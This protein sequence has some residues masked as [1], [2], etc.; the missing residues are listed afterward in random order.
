MRARF[1][2]IIRTYLEPHV[3]SVMAAP[4]QSIHWGIGLRE[5]IP[6]I[7][8]LLFHSSCFLFFIFTFS[9]KYK[10]AQFFSIRNWWFLSSQGLELESGECFLCNVTGQK[11]WEELPPS[12]EWVLPLFP[13]RVVGFWHV[14]KVL[15]LPQSWEVLLLWVLTSQF[16]CVSLW[17]LGPQSSFHHPHFGAVFGVIL[18]QGGALALHGG[19][20]QLRAAFQNLSDQSA[21]GEGRDTVWLQ[22]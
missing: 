15:V 22:L 9:V 13:Q 6:T 2:A 7:N 12:S 5:S 11:D 14:G 17:S 21:Q 16:N 19:E 4:S 10:Q 1:R 3:G 8:L 20:G 18:F